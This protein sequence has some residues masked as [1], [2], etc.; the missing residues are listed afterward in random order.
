MTLED[1][2]SQLAMALE[3]A[4]VPYMVTGSVASSVHGTPRSTRDLDIVISPTHHQLLALVQQFPDSRYYADEQQALEALAKRSQFNVIDSLSGWKVDFI[5]AND[6]EYGRTALAR[7]RLIDIAGVAMYVT[8]AE[9]VIV[10]KM[11][12]AM[13]GGSE[14]Q[15][16]DA[17]GILITQSSNLD[18][19]Y[20]ER[21]VTEL[22][23]EKQ[24]Q[25]VRQLS[26]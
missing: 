1:L 3:R 10:S 19:A 16:Q 9:D 22:E 7:R 24:W 2:L 14:R 20:V 6:S 8:S 21:W 18:V 11:Q 12:W 13:Q 17:A 15:L 23:L 4:H 26:Q 25:A 5:I